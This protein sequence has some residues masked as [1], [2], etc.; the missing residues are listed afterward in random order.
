GEGGAGPDREAPFRL[1]DF[2][3]EVLE[4]FRIGAG[5]FAEFLAELRG[6]RIDQRLVPV[7]AAEV[8]VAAAGDDAD[9]VLLVADERQVERTAPQIVNENLL[10]VGEFGKP[11]SLGTENVAQRRGDRFVD[12][13]N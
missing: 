5:I 6:G 8:Q 1:L 9:F 7:D 3:G 2:P 13:V 4:T 10:L 12:N 11:E